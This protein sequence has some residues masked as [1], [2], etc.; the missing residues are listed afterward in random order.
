LSH[1]Q[2]IIRP[3]TI[4]HSPA[5]EPEKR[6]S[7]NFNVAVLPLIALVVTIAWAVHE[8]RYYEPGDNFGYY[9]GVV[10]GV[11]ML[12]LL[13]YSARK[14]FH[15]MRNW[16]ATKH[17]FRF[18]MILGIVG[19]TLIL[20]HSTF[21]AGS[22]NAIVAL[23]CMIL[24][25]SSG[26]VGRFIYSKIH[27]GLYGRSATLQEVQANL[28]IIGGD[29]KS[30]FHFAPNIEKR[31]K[32]FEASTLSEDK[33]TW[34]RLTSFVTVGIRARWTYYAA[35]R[36]LKRLGRNHAAKHQW[37][38]NKLEKRLTAGKMAI[39]KYL[40][41]VIDVTRFTTYERLFS[42]WHVIHIPFLFMLV[43]SGVVHVI[44]VHMY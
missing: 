38:A 3:A 4:I 36:E 14:Y 12:L 25:A 5:T 37:N 34:S 44:A 16:G 24:V 19:P 39:Q 35:V 33:G 10:G 28:G 6:L 20:F 22:L 15:F 18:H 11:M 31:L 9:L 7:R 23:S 17:W 40:S 32:E 8:G 13:L 30:I 21:R 27:H 43:I 2:V 41:A 42:L 1:D 26:I 29:V